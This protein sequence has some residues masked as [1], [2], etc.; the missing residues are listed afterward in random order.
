MLPAVT[1][2]SPDI[3]T[4]PRFGSGR[5]LTSVFSTLERKPLNDLVLKDIF[6]FNLPYMALART[7]QEL[8]DML[9]NQLGLLAVTIGS[10]TL[11][12]PLLRKPAAW[13]SGQSEASLKERLSPELLKTI[14]KKAK[15]ARLGVSFGLLFPFAAGFMAVPFMRDWLTVERSG[16]ANFEQLIGLKQGNKN[17]TAEDTQKSIDHYKSLFFKT[18]GAG[19][20]LGAASL[21]GFSLASRRAGATANKLVDGLFNNFSLRG[22]SSGEVAGVA[23][24]MLFWLLPPYVG[25]MMAARDKTERRE[26]MIKGVNSL[27]WFSL[28]TPFFLKGKAVNKFAKL[29]IDTGVDKAK[30]TLVKGFQGSIPTYEAIQKLAPEVKEKALKV[31]DRYAL[32]SWLIPVTMLGLSPQ[33]FNIFF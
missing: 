23:S 17:E 21:V 3:P 16:T 24:T 10:M 22:K 9:P 19:F 28:F 2:H 14:G 13:I 11:M 31:K 15:L 27:L 1:R 30:N 7:T 4:S 26:F 32:L 18:L 12:P 5:L 20:G 6:C 33:M 25:W 8:R 29:G